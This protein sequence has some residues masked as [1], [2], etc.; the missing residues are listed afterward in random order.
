MVLAEQLEVLETGFCA[1]QRAFRGLE[2]PSQI[3]TAGTG[4]TEQS[5]Q[6]SGLIVVPGEDLGTGVG[7]LNR[8]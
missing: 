8:H 5:L 4:V 6:N 2:L 7:K 3:V 1:K